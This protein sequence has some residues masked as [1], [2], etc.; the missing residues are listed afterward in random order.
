VNGT[1][2]LTLENLTKHFYLHAYQE[3][4]IRGFENVSFVLD[5]GQSLGLSGPSG[6][7]KSSILKCIYRTYLPSN[8]SIGFCSKRYGTVDF[9]HLPERIMHSIRTEE[10]GYVSQFLR[11]IPRVSAIDVVSEPL[12]CRG[13]SR[14]TAKRKASLLLERL[15]IPAN[16]HDAYPS[17]F[18]GGEQQ[19]INVARAVIWRPKLLL[20]DEPTAS[21]D[22]LSVSVVMD[23]L[24]EL[25]R[26]GVAMIGVFHDE[27][28]MSTLV[29]RVYKI[30]KRGLN[31]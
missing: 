11:V 23:I 19:R 25:K 2:L 12:V 22:A 6:S 10:I 5:A 13:V 4:V 21:L 18:S 29:D 31:D 1:P 30:N 9:S 7:G 20:L 3:K 17:T 8:G 15:L 28:L 24:I 14:T 27:T 16:L 26:E